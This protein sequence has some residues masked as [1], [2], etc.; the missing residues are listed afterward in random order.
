MALKLWT[1]A[2]GRQMTLFVESEPQTGYRFSKDGLRLVHFGVKPGMN[3]WEVLGGQGVPGVSR[4]RGSQLGLHQPLLR[5][6]RPGPHYRQRSRRVSVGHRYWRCVAFPELHPT[7]FAFAHPAR[8]DFLRAARMV[9][10]MAGSM[11]E[12]RGIVRFQVWPVRMLD[13]PTGLGRSAICGSGVDAAVD[14]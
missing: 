9:L 11:T 6:G 10:S 14:P 4:A 8:G 1:P 2:T 3:F 7:R 5:S 13:L 12:T